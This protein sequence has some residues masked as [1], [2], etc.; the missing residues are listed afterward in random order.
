M[1]KEYLGD[2]VYVETVDG[3]IKLTTE[4]GYGSSNIIYLEPLVFKALIE[5]SKRVKFDHWDES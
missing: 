1:N 2:S 4:N 5:Y 3:M